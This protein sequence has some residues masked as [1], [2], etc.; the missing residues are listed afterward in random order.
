L[1]IVN[2][3]DVAIFEM[4]AERIF[5][6]YLF[7]KT[8]FVWALVCIGVSLGMRASIELSGPTSANQT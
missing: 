5:E 8:Y 3:Y 7:K 4:L 1:R 2:N 6:R